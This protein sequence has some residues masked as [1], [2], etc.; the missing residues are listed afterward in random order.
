M[1]LLKVEKIETVGATYFLGPAKFNGISS[2]FTYGGDVRDFKLDTSTFVIDYD[3]LQLRREFYMP[4]YDTEQVSNRMP[5]FRNLLFWSPD[6]TTDNNGKKEISFY[7]SD[8]PGKY[9]VV[10]QGFS[11][12]GKAGSKVFMIDV[13][14]ESIAAK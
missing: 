13:K 5:D 14:K 4:A 11:D 10:M 7:T 1:I 2:F 6:I 9:A 8:I 3:A 12:A